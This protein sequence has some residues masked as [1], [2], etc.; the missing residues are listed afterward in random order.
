MGI[1]CISRKVAIDG[2][3]GIP[4][5]LLVFTQKT[6][7]LNQLGPFYHRVELMTNPQSCKVHCG[8]QGRAR[9][10]DQNHPQSRW[11]GNITE[12]CPPG[13]TAFMKL[14]EAEGSVWCGES[15]P[16]RHGL[17]ISHASKATGFWDLFPHLKNKKTCFLCRVLPGLTFWWGYFLLLCYYC[18]HWVC[19]T[20]MENEPSEAVRSPPQANWVD[21]CLLKLLIPN[22]P[23]LKQ[24]EKQWPQVVHPWLCGFYILCRRLLWGSKT[25]SSFLYILN[26]EYTLP[27]TSWL[28]A[29]WKI[30]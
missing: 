25:L 24:H 2:F 21:L 15:P 20:D 9:E 4:M 7:L 13:P 8:I 29:L 17:A 11:Q 30:S 16:G 27:T 12:H 10:G 28:A 6:I 19:F 22:S 3:S 23:S 14:Q 5:G 1:T 18:P 26:P